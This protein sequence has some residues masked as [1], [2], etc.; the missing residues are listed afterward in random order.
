MNRLEKHIFNSR[1]TEEFLSGFK[2][3]ETALDIL[4]E[5]FKPDQQRLRRSEF[6][7][8]RSR[9]GFQ[10]NAVHDAINFRAKVAEQVSR[11]AVSGRIGYFTHS[12]DCDCAYGEYR[13]NRS[14]SDI[15]SLAQ[16][17]ERL[18]EDAEGPTG[19]SITAPFEEEFSHSSRDLALEAFEDGHPH[20]VHF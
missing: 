15:F 14:A 16:D 7:A 8:Y 20:S 1:Y 9:K 4:R 17:I 3:R 13:Q 5:F 18:Y 11:V 2:A 12:M 10:V 19:Y 6:A